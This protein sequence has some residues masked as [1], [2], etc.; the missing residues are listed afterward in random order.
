MDK[1]L[2]YNS[3]KKEMKENNISNNIVFLFN[4]ESNLTSEDY[5]K[6]LE[7][8]K[9]NNILIIDLYNTI[10]IEKEN[11][12]VIDVKKELNKDSFAIDGI[13]LNDKGNK[14]VKKILDNNL[15]KD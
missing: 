1:K 8:Y 13:H 2:D 5:N 4:K 10:N 14:I 12:K 11:I 15:K 7:D 3:L 9:N 6:I